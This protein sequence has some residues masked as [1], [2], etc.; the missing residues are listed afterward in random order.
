VYR[1][2][3]ADWPDPFTARFVWHVP[4]RLDLTSMRAA[5]RH[6]VGHHDFASFCRSTR[7][8]TG[9]VRTLARLAVSAG[10]H[11][12][13]VRAAAPSFLHQMVRSLTGTL[14]AVGRGRIDPGAMP[15]IL[16][17][18][19]RSAAPQMAPAHGLMLVRVRYRRGSGRG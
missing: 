13:E 7:P 4:G 14:V 9:S 8:P 1:I 19:S 18:R 10:G 2:D 17:A 6:L 12:I 16:A 5:A 3:T 15:M 11:R